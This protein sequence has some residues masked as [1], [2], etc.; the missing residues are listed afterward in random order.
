VAIK[1]HSLI[2]GIA[3]YI[4]GLRKLSGRS[5]GGTISAR[6]CYSVWL[7]HLSFLHRSGLP[8]TF[9]TVAE[10]GPGDSL[11]IGLATLLCGAERYLALDAVRYADSARNLQIFEELI[12]VFR[13]RAPIP[14]EA[15]F[16]LVQP[17]LASYAFPANIL[18]PARLNSALD[19]NRLDAIRASIKNPS[20]RLHEGAPVCYI[21]PWQPSS[22]KSGTVDLV[23]SQTVLEFPSD[24]ADLYA[25]MARWLKP[26]GVM[27]H[28]IDFKSLGITAEWNG[29]WACSDTLWHLA[30]GK[31]R[32]RPNREPHSTHIALLERVG[33]RVICDERTLRPSE[34]TRAQLRP[35]FRD[36][37]D[38]DL[39][40][41]SALI[42]AT[43]MS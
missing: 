20:V 9:E 32:H 23:L 27:S 11:G 14:D 8:T 33:C 15:E 7:R 1:V 13:D 25:D 21:A 24:L 4:P 18:P 37:T 22:I 34:I 16:P 3:T 10:L 31:R 19:P 29:H 12:A 35:R 43:K 6:Y 38:D 28:E 36:L 41:S 39:R 2:V 5:T 26:G 42:Q 30:T 17:R 40:T